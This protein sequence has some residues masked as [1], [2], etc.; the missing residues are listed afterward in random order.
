MHASRQRHQQWPRPLWVCGV[1]AIMFLS[2]C[3]SSNVKKAEQHMA[4]GMYKQSI[5]LLE[6]EID[7][8]PTTAKAHFLSGKCNL[9]TGNVREAE[10]SFDRAMANLAARVS[11][12]PGATTAL[13][14]VS[15]LQC[16]LGRTCP[17]VGISFLGET[18]KGGDI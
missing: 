15:L 14:K 16:G 6:Q 1:V 9:A 11:E 13:P 10:R 8:K 3:R 17:R 12:S 2:G 5:A 7:D 18:T 4:A